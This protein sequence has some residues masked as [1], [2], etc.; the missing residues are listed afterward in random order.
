MSSSKKKP[1]PTANKNRTPVVETATTNLYGKRRPE[2]IRDG[3]DAAYSMFIT[4][5]AGSTINSATSLNVLNWSQSQPHL[6]ECLDIGYSMYLAANQGATFLSIRGFDLIG[7]LASQCTSS[8]PSR[9][10]D[11]TNAP[12]QPRAMAANASAGGETAAQA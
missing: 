5:N 4:A 3:V 9:I 11:R 6:Q 1:T 8:T 10:T 12:P 2:T 7:F